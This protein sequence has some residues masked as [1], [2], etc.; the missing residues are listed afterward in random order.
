MATRF[1]VVPA[2]YVLLV[3]GEGADREVLL[4]L[5][6]PATDYRP[7]HWAS[8]AAG[9]VEYGESVAAAAVREGREELGI[10]LA[11]SDLEPLCTL[12]R[13]L[14]GCPD[15]IEQRV[16][17]FLT[18]RVW[19]GEPAVR[20]PGKAGELRWCRLDGL[21]E[22]MVPHELLV[23]RRLAAGAVPAFLSLGFDG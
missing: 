14:P 2:A 15:P 11:E 6:G 10:E 22:P 20:E 18:T 9:H 8:G 7:G 12:Q 13:T 19:A 17:F 21:P 3:R 4:Q 23:L 1:Q 5:R 16:D